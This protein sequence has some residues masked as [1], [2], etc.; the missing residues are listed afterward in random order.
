[1]CVKNPGRKASSTLNGL[2]ERKNNIIGYKTH[3]Y[4]CCSISRQ[5][6]EMRRIFLMFR[7]QSERICE[8]GWQAP[9]DQD[10]CSLSRQRR[11][12]NQISEIWRSSGPDGIYPEFFHHLH[13][14]CTLWLTT[15]YTTRL[16]LERLP[17]SWRKVVVAILK[18]HK[19]A[20]EPTSY[21][22]VSHVLA[23]RS[24]NAIFI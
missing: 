9:D 4:L 10:L 18:P 8:E 16:H 3:D 11:L 23:S 24:W 5:Q 17:K 7:P 14:N 19:P 2:T 22:P 6:L 15:F 13:K 21:E 12:S 20:T 1:M